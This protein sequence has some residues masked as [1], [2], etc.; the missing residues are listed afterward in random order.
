MKLYTFTVILFI[1]GSFVK[2]SGLGAFNGINT[3]YS[4]LLISPSCCSSQTTDKLK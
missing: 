2:S 4:Q 3:T 1:I